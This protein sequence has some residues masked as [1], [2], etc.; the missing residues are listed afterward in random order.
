MIPA[1][2]KTQENTRNGGGPKCP[3]A[4]RRPQTEFNIVGLEKPSFPKRRVPPAQWPD[5]LLLDE[6]YRSV[7]SEVL[8]VPLEKRKKT[9][10][11]GGSP[12][13]L[14]AGRRSPAEL[15][16]VGWEKAGFSKRGVAHTEGP[17]WLLLTEI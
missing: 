11:N 3:C 14:C 15:N 10:G 7:R 1:I 17:D 5:K 4:G 9:Q 16:L 2:L 13:S 8:L 12:K 6:I